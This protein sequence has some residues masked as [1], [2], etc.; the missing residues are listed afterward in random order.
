MNHSTSGQLALRKAIIG[1]TNFKTAEGQSERSVDSYKRD[2]EHWAAYARDKEV[3]QF[4][5]RISRPIYSI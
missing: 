4:T 3:A 1:F 2:L 5:N